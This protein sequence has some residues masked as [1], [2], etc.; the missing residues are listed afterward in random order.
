MEE[1]ANLTIECVGSDTVPGA[2][3]A[4]SL[5]EALQT[6]GMFVG[7]ASFMFAMWAKGF[8]SHVNGCRSLIRRN[9]I[10]LR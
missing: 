2:T 8:Q 7:G 6:V 4:I 10:R 9:L 1:P 3:S 5:D